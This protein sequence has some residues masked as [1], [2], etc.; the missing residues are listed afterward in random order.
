MGTIDGLELNCFKNLVRTNLRRIKIEKNENLCT[1]KTKTELCNLSL[2]KWSSNTLL[3]DI[4]QLRTSC[5]LDPMEEEQIKG[6]QKSGF[7]LTT[8]VLT[9]PNTPSQQEQQQEASAAESSKQE[10]KKEEYSELLKRYQALRS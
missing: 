4:N 2:E 8:S 9:S 7:P 10:N 1:T 6:I 5:G 3:R